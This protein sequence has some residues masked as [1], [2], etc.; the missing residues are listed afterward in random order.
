[1]SSRGR[2]STEKLQANCILM[3]RFLSAGG[4]SVERLEGQITKYLG[5]YM[6]G[7]GPP[8]KRTVQDWV[9]LTP[10]FP[11][12]ALRDKIILEK[13]ILH[14]LRPYLRGE[15]FH[16]DLQQEISSI[17]QA[18]SGLSQGQAAAVGIGFAYLLTQLSKKRP[19][20]QRMR[21]TGRRVPRQ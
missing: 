12:T 18:D 21:L 2:Q 10:D 20:R 4:Y 8:A 15:E 19:P 11:E 9:K 3:K 7:K 5:P 1:M 16:V 6:K 17:P 14:W 13:D